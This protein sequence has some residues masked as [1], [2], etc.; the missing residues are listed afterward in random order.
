MIVESAAEFRALVK[1]TFEKLTDRVSFAA[2]WINEFLDLQRL[3]G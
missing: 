2:N 3:C 1:E